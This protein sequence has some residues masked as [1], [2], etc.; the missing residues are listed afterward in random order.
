M[1]RQ[2]GGD[3]YVLPS[4]L[5]ECI[6]LP[7]KDSGYMQAEYLQEMVREVNQKTVEIDDLLGDSVY[8]YYADTDK[9]AI[10]A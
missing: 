1:L 9:L 4:S 6:I 5:H 7:A 3:Y 8:R 10:V 2:I